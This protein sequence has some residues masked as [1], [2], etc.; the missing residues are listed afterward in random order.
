MRGQAVWQPGAG[1][2]GAV[3]GA[4]QRRTG[5]ETGEMNIKSPMPG[6][7]VAVRV[8]V[9][10]EVTAGQTVVILE[11][12]KMQNELKAPRD[13]VGA[14]ASMCRQGKV[15]NKQNLVTMPNWPR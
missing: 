7:I 15:S 9:G 10:Q 5:Y 13:G 8:E 11:S 2:T 3:D 1:R 6:L 12:M 14:G 4:A